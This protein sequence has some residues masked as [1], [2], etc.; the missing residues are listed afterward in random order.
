MGGGRFAG[1]EFMVVYAAEN[2]CGFSR[3]GISVGKSY[4]TAVMRNRL[5]RLVREVFRQNQDNLPAGFDYL[6]MVSRQFLQEKK[7]KKQTGQVLEK[8]TFEQIEGSFLRLAYKAVEKS[9]SEQ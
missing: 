1:D 4:G 3:L 7:A 9:K 2:E 6:V 5:K 8:L